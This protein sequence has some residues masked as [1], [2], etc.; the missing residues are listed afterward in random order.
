MIYNKIVY[1]LLVYIV[2][3]ITNTD[4]IW[5]SNKYALELI[6]IADTYNRPNKDNFLNS[7]KSGELTKIIDCLLSDYRE[8]ISNTVLDYYECNKLRVVYL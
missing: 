6:K 8:Y 7:Y 4:S 3:Y 2:S 1:N 5:I